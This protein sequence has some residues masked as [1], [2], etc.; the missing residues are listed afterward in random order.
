MIGFQ[1][2]ANV[3]PL[4]WLQMFNNKEIQ[5]LISGAPIPVNVSDLREHSVY[6]GELLGTHV[7]GAGTH[8]LI[9]TFAGGYTAEHQTIVH[10]WR[11][12][13]E[14]NDLQRRQLLKFVTSCSR[15]PLLGFKVYLCHHFLTRYKPIFL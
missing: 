15:P 10:F 13:E 9:T 14:F 8:K 1:G 12:L 4:E 2:L 6:A 11:V 5:V 7:V 3:I